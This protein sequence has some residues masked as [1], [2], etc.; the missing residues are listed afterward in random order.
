MKTPLWIRKL[1][2][3]L[4]AATASRPSKPFLATNSAIDS[5]MAWRALTLANLSPVAFL[6]RKQPATSSSGERPANALNSAS[7]AS[8]RC[9]SS[10]GSSPCPALSN[11]RRTVS[12][13]AISDMGH[14]LLG[15]TEAASELLDL[16]LPVGKG[17]GCLEHPFALEALG[18]LGHLCPGVAVVAVEEVLR[19]GPTRTLTTR[20][21]ILGRI[22]D[23]Q[24]PHRD[25]VVGDLQHFLGDGDV[26]GVQAHPQPLVA[27]GQ[28]RPDL[29]PLHRAVRIE[30][31]NT[32][33]QAD[34]LFEFHGSKAPLDRDGCAA[35]DP[36]DVP[37]LQSSGQ[38]AALDFLRRGAGQVV[39]HLD[40]I[41]D[42]GSLQ[43]RL[44]PAE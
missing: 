4:P 43:T 13:E 32:A 18:D 24:Y 28:H 7:R 1:R 12:D 5:F 10:G 33:A 17:S 41:G 42:M 6:R 20:L 15:E 16:F 36:G 30:V 29:L 31:P 40:D 35:I 8:R 25:P 21:G 9:C 26:E 2:R 38:K 19:E 11:Q 39:D 34:D 22:A 23:Q 44:A 3:T 37:F 14:C 27:A